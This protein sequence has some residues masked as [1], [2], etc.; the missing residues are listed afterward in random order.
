MTICME[1]AGLNDTRP[2][3]LTWNHGERSFSLEI[4]KNIY[5]TDLEAGWNENGYHVTL[6]PMQAE[7]P[8]NDDG[9]GEHRYWMLNIIDISGD[10]PK[11]IGSGSVAWGE[12]F[13]MDGLYEDD[14]VLTDKTIDG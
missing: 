2:F 12:F 14:M 8:D 4:P 3:L 7:D 5:R 9:N 1:F 6:T 13:V 11:Q 10:E